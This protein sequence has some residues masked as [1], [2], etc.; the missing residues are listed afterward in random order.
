[1]LMFDI[2]HS[3]NR[4]Y[5]ASIVYMLHHTYTIDFN[6]LFL[7]G[8]VPCAVYKE[9]NTTH[10]LSFFNSDDVIYVCM[11]LCLSGS[12]RDGCSRNACGHGSCSGLEDMYVCMYVCMY[13][14]CYIIHIPS[15]LMDYFYSGV[16]RI[17]GAQHDS[18]SFFFQFR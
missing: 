13:C 6:G 16:R 3:I 10:L 14:S 9:C 7:F 1:M 15:I 2:V 12:T 5:C 8:C 18:P 17:Q 4:I 11:V